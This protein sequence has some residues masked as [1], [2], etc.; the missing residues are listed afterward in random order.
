MDIICYIYQIIFE[1]QLD[2]LG[3]SI[4]FTT[5]IFF[6]NL[7]WNTPF[8]VLTLP[9][10]IGGCQIKSPWQW[11]SQDHSDLVNIPEIDLCSSSPCS[12]PSWAPWTTSATRSPSPCSGAW[13]T[14]QSGTLTPSIRCSSQFVTQ[15]LIVNILMSQADK[16][17][18]GNVTMV[19]ST[20]SVHLPMV[21]QVRW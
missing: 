11:G 8:P 1:N 7:C 5:L 17:S 9:R 20:D 12:G 14:G 3:F 18:G 15:L 19:T 16:W 2:T 4:F 10:D 13:C 6:L 21:V